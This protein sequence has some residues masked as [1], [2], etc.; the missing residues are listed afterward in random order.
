MYQ[1][2]QHLIDIVK[3]MIDN[4]VQHVRKLE[5][6]VVNLRNTSAILVVPRQ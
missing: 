5:V 6:K 4:K 3:P 1:I 2:S